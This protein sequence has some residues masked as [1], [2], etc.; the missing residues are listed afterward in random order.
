MVIATHAAP[1]QAP[2]GLLAQ[3]KET[4]FKFVKGEDFD[5]ARIIFKKIIE[6]D[7]SDI[8]ARLV[9]AQL[10]DDGTHKKYAESRD[11][12]LSILDEHPAIFRPTSIC[13]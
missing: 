8:N 2:D 13:T 9:Y 5:S 12:M 1:S 3:L 7:R 11:L 10:I 6:L 4:G